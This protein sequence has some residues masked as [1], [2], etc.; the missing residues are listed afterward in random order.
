MADPIAPECH[1]T[2]LAYRSASELHSLYTRRSISPV[3]VTKALIARIERLQP[4]LN[5]FVVFDPER[6]I[7]AARASETRYVHDSALGAL[8]GVPVS[9]KDLLPARG[10]PTRHGSLT[11]P[12]NG[13]W[14]E[15][16]PSVARLRE[17]GAVLLGKTTTSEFGLKGLGDSP[18]TGVTRNPWNPAHTPGGSS[19]G[20]VVSVAAGLSTIAIGTDGGGSIRV[21]SSHSGVLGLKP[22][23]GRVPASPPGFVGVPPH[24][25]PIARSVADLALT[26]AVISR[27]DVR[28]PWQPPLWAASFLTDD[29]AHWRRLRIGY[30]LDLGY[31][32][33]EP[34]VASAFE[35]ALG[36]LRAAG[37]RLEPVKLQLPSPA[38]SLQTLF[39]ARAAWTVR[40]LGPAQRAQLD[41]VVRAAAEQGERLSAVAYLDAEAERLR[42]VQA[43]GQ[44]HADYDLLL[45]PASAYPAPLTS[46]DPSAPAG[47][48]VRASLAAPFSLTRQPALSIPIGLTR[49]GLPVGLQIV[50]RHYDESSV[51]ELARAYERLHPLQLPPL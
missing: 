46:A 16:A 31:A 3:E 32:D 26:L 34:D 44:Y 28:D 42:T 40:A 47:K 38:D 25:G 20:A 15:D 10:W 2:E 49:T 12:E 18:L 48:P 33:V 11:T 27:P 8:D 9:I 37:A 51:L 43:L 35:T 1:V 41:P 21:P 19:A 30:S 17:A 23:F 36:V 39:A 6:A 14:D 4:S 45:T 29:E 7:E 22:T 13:A 50:G 5:A 24:V